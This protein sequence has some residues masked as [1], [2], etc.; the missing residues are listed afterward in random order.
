M[1]PCLVTSF[2]VLN[3]QRHMMP[4]QREVEREILKINKEIEDIK[5]SIK[6]EVLTDRQK[7]VKRNKIR[8]LKAIRK[9]LDKASGGLESST[10]LLP[11]TIG[12]YRTGS[13]TGKPPPQVDK[14]G[15]ASNEPLNFQSS[16]SISMQLNGR[17]GAPV[18]CI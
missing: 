7:E 1:T 3:V 10:C 5:W 6:N 15:S 11:K 13:R 12:T 4:S 16:A 17:R 9:K 2:D 14:W 8:E 18:S